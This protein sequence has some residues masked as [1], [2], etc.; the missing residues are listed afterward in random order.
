MLSEPHFCFATLP[1]K[2]LP[3]S[4]C[5]EQSI[6]LCL[7]GPR[8]AGKAQIPEHPGKGMNQLQRNVENCG[9]YGLHKAC[10]KQ[11]TTMLPQPSIK[12]KPGWPAP[13]VRPVV[14]RATGATRPAAAGPLAFELKSSKL[15]TSHNGNAAMRTF[16]HWASASSRNQI[17]ISAWW[18]H[19]EMLQFL[20]LSWLWFLLA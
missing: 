12:Y 18:F 15:P 4:M 13:I 7:V 14:A 17:Q 9:N 10:P 5:S 20:L 2:T 1:S 11:T 19:L 16:E 8:A 3:A 6:L